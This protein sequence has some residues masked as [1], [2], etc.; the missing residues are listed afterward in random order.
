MESFAPYLEQSKRTKKPIIHISLNPHPKDKLTD[1]QLSKMA[2]DFMERFGYGD[3]PYLIFKH[4]DIKRQHLHIVSCRIDET[5]K[6]IEHDYEGKRANTICLQME[7]D[8]KLT[9]RKS[10]K[11][12][13][14]AV[15][16]APV[17]YTDGNIKRNIKS[18]A[19]TLKEK[20]KFG[21][22]NEFRALLSLYNI[23]LD[24]VSGEVKGKA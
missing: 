22:I 19:L 17:E 15:S 8:Y 2:Q 11:D 21:S 7:K 10:N 24:H 18:I 9:P 23:S 5:G 13:D 20:Y 16:L 14:D 12:I 1:E 6:K 3:Q 4:E